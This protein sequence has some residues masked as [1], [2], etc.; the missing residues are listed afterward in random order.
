MNE[1]DVINSL[2]K[3]E[4]ELDK[5]L[6]EAKRTALKIKEDALRKAGEIKT[7]GMKE[8]EEMLEK[9]K[10]AEMGRIDEEVDAIQKK[11]MEEAERLKIKAGERFDE[12]VEKVVRYVIGE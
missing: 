8:I 7:S 2:R 4:E 10:T 12:V 1:S 3:K 5:L 11:A 9:Y 6:D